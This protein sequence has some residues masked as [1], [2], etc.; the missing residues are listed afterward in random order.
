MGVGGADA[1]RGI[2][3]DPAELWNVRFGPGVSP[4]FRGLAVGAVEMSGYEA[5]RN[6]SGARTGREDV[7]IV[8]AH[9]ALQLESFACRSADI[10]ERSDAVLRTAMS[11]VRIVGQAIGDPH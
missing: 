5:G 3:T 4:F 1:V 8:L 9:A 2:E 11:R 6:T 10:G 7:R